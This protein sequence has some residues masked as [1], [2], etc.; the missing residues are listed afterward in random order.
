[1]QMRDTFFTVELHYIILMMIR[2]DDMISVTETAQEKLGQLL[3]T[4]NAQNVMIRLFIK[5]LG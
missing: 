2:G 5:G 3:E 1:M 4:E